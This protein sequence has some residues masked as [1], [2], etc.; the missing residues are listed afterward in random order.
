MREGLVRPLL[1][2]FGIAYD[3][4]RCSMAILD[5]R[6]ILA[7]AVRIATRQLT[8]NLCTQYSP[9]L[10]MD[11]DQPT[12]RLGGIALHHLVELTHLVPQHI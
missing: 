2:A 12:T 11:K 7:M 8:H 9:T 5:K 4:E 10:A 6:G 3:D 1:G